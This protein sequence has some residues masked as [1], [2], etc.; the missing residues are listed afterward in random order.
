MG[1]ARPAGGPRVGAAGPG[2]ARAV[3]ILRDGVGRAR[4]IAVHGIREAVAAAGGVGCWVN[5]R[6]T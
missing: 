3:G 2:P 4:P 6:E 5:R 1:A